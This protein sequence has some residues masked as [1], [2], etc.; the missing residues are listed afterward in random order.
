MVK[1]DYAEY[2][3][4]TAIRIGRFKNHWIYVDNSIKRKYTQIY[5]YTHEIIMISMNHSM[6]WV[7][8][9]FRGIVLVSL[10]FSVMQ[11]E[12]EEDYSCLEESKALTNAVLVSAY[13]TRWSEPT[14]L[15][16]SQIQS[17]GPNW[18]A[19]RSWLKHPQSLFCNDL[20]QPVKNYLQNCFV[21]VKEL[22]KA[23][24]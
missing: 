9:P 13:T 24:Q 20:R 14:G 22:C 15:T 17:P 8:T 4:R 11:R 12:K 10:Q 16:S 5:I 2:Q 23:S 18:L 7:L 19:H 21:F 3:N 1:A 6:I